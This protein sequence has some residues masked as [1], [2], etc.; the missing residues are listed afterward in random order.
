MSQESTSGTI[1][2]PAEE[3][4]KEA[5]EVR[6]R[7]KI[8]AGSEEEPSIRLLGFSE[9]ATETPAERAA[10]EAEEKLEKDLTTARDEY[11]KISREFKKSGNGDKKALEEAQKKYSEARR[12]ELEHRLGFFEE[13]FDE[14]VKR[15][16]FKAEDRKKEIARFTKFGLVN[17]FK[18][19]YDAKT[20]L[21]I[22]EKKETIANRIGKAAYRAFDWYRKLPAWKK[23][24]AGVALMGVGWAGGATAV[25]AASVAGA[26]TAMRLMGSGG[27][28][29]TIEA[30]LKKRDERKLAREIGKALNVGEGVDTA[31][32]SAREGK[33]AAALTEFLKANDAQLLDRYADNEEIFR[34]REGALRKRRWLISAA[35]GAAMF[36]GGLALSKL[37]H[38]SGGH[39]ATTGHAPGSAAGAPKV[40]VV[41]GD[42]VEM[43]DTVWNSCR[44]LLNQQGI[45]H[46]TPSE[47]MQVAEQV[48]KDNHVG[49]AP[50]NIPG[51]SLDVAMK[52]GEHLKLTKMVGGLVKEIVAKHAGAPSHGVHALGNEVVPHPAHE[53]SSIPPSPHAPDVPISHPA[54]ATAHV[55]GESAAANVP[56]VHEAA[57]PAAPLAGDQGWHHFSHQQGEH[58]F[59]GTHGKVPAPPAPD[60]AANAQMNTVDNF[61]SV[62]HSLQ[63][64]IGFL[65]SHAHDFSHEALGRARDAVFND[66]SF[67]F[68]RRYNFLEQQEALTRMHEIVAKAT[69]PSLRDWYQGMANALEHG[70]AYQHSEGVFREMLGRAGMNAKEYGDVKNM[71]VGKFLGHHRWHSIADWFKSPYAVADPTHPQTYVYRGWGGVRAT[72]VPGATPER[73]Y[74]SRLLAEEMRQW[75]LT[76]AS[77]TDYKNLTVDECLKTMIGPES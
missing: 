7:Y 71:T 44:I 41:I 75:F 56:H 74:H 26:S 57:S 19:L 54:E 66:Q 35:G 62:P 30:L 73:I 65:N 9:G 45:A 13:T 20:N 39:G 38:G 58:P 47:I 23:V 21:E 40:E 3:P 60:A 1:P 59:T 68:S 14:E 43:K 64:E 37:I 2:T 17:E 67:D 32:Q 70:A 12:D 49:V 24:T 55:S 15:G 33:T 72:T 69:D 46:P 18:Q 5:G 27:M 8:V 63:D 77:S 50:W 53:V 48:A 42:Q 4:K 29:L 52:Q 76:R 51:S 22:A 34:K 10:R 11:A 31:L 61:F 6:P 25:V 36:A 16:T 28:T